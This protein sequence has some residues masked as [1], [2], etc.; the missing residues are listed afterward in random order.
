[1]TI[2]GRD[3]DLLST[4]LSATQQRQQV[5]MG[6]LANAETPGWTRK[7]VEFESLLAEQMGKPNFDP[8]QVEPQILDDVLTPGRPDGNNVHM[9]L[10]LNSLRENKLMYQTYSALLKHRFNSIDAALREG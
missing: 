10:E 3:V 1:M 2:S 4:L 7:T 8:K 9:E 6:N 5:I